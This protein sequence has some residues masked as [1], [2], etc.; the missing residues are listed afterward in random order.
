MLLPKNKVNKGEG[1]SMDLKLTELKNAMIA[2]TYK[3][4]VVANNLAN[5]NTVGYKR[6]MMFYQILDTNMESKLQMKTETDFSQG[7]LKQ[8][9]NPLDFAISGA[10][11]FTIEMDGKIAYTRDGHFT[12]DQEGILKTTSGRPVLGQGGWI[13]ISRDGLKIGEISV[14]A[15]GDIYTDSQLVD[16]Y[17][18]DTLRIT[19][20]D[21]YSNLKKVGENLFIAE[22]GVNP[23]ELDEP[24]IIQGKLEG[25]NVSPVTEMIKLIELQRSFESSQR[26]IRTI[27]TALGRAV[28]EI[29]RFR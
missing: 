4:D 29:S 21:T 19:D 14:S 7:P 13:N 28:R 10:G 17:L 26:A 1:I 20:F 5:V 3:N 11:F 23:N 15:R 16:S 8:T 24:T 2:Q 27:D 22:E 18:I 9:N 12:V 25:S 6:D